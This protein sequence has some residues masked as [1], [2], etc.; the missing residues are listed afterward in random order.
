MADDSRE[1]ANANAEEGDPAKTGATWKA[2][3]VVLVLAV[4]VTLAL[5]ALLAFGLGCGCTR[6]A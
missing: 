4:A 1:E 6:P 5:W 3:A 2:L